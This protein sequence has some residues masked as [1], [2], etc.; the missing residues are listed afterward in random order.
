VNPQPICSLENAGLFN[1]PS[2]GA[3]LPVSE[4]D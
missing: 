3:P 1:G 2:D 4:V